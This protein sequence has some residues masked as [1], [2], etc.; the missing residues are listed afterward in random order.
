MFSSISIFLPFLSR[1]DISISNRLAALSPRSVKK[2]QNQA[3]SGRM[4]DFSL[5]LPPLQNQHYINLR[6][7]CVSGFLNFCFYFLI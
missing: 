3:I 4:G 7:R 2:V 6:R 1:L 5:R